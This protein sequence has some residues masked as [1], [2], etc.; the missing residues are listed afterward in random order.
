M[1]FQWSVT[2]MDLLLPSV[3]SSSLAV[4]SPFSPAYFSACPW[5]FWRVFEVGHNF[6]SFGIKDKNFLSPSL[7]IVVSADIGKTVSLQ[8]TIV[9]A[10]DVLTIQIVISIT[11]S[12]GN[13][14]WQICKRNGQ[15]DVGTQSYTS[16]PS[17]A[18]MKQNHVSAWQ[19]LEEKKCMRSM[20]IQLFC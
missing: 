9:F 6:E 14:G 2:L 20:G 3:L 11:V 4:L 5:H 17:F 10:S 19:G 13:H 7:T 18:E 1:N 16:R 8:N 12:L 15:K